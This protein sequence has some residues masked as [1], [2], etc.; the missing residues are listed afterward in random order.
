MHDH[1]FLIVSYVEKFDMMCSNTNF[2]N[3]YMHLVLQW[4]GSKIL[5]LGLILLQDLLN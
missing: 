4:V 2:V 1:F 3:C 5:W